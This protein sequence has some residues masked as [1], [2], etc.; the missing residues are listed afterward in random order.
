M[1]NLTPDLPKSSGVISQAIRLIYWAYF[2]GDTLVSSVTDDA[3]T[4]SMSS[5]A[6]VIFVRAK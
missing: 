2:S 3:I 5:G 6:Q 4:I 1:P